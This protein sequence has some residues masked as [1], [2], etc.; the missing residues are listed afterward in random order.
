L[1]LAV[2]ERIGIPATDLGSM[3]AGERIAVRGASFMT[4]AGGK[5][6]RIVT[7]S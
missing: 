2:Y 7:S 4:I 6:A 5:P 1:V 3:K